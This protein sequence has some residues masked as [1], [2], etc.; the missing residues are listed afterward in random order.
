MVRAAGLAFLRIID[1]LFF[2]WT[3]KFQLKLTIT[4][5]LGPAC[6]HNGVKISH[7]KSLTM[8][9]F[10]LPKYQNIEL[11]VLNKLGISK[12]LQIIANHQ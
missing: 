3:H 1:P 5:P 10:C 8:S 2:L 6:T 7:A 4:H 11:H 12:L 9:H